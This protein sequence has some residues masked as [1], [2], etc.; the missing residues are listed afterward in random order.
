M[1]WIFAVSNN[2]VGII[3]VVVFLNNG[4]GASLL[5]VAGGLILFKGRLFNDIGWLHGL[6]AKIFGSAWLLVGVSLLVVHLLLG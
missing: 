5:I 3:A 2:L 1:N 6:P 4:F